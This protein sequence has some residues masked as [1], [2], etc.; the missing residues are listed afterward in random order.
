MGRKSSNEVRAV[1][2]R[3][4]FILRLIRRFKEAEHCSSTDVIKAA[5]WLQDMGTLD[6]LYDQTSISEVAMRML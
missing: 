5:H 1:Y 6:I 3:S 2:D 4:N